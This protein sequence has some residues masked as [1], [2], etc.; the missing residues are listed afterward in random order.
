PTTSRITSSPQM[1]SNSSVNLIQSTALK[2]LPKFTSDP[3]Q[4]VAQFI[5]GG[6]RFGTFTKLNESLL[7]TI[8][9]IELGGAAF[10]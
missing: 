9:T 6:E 5:D 3:Q 10:N 7:H 1:E 4:K 8:A 2:E